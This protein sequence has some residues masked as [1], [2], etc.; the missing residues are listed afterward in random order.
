MSFCKSCNPPSRT[1]DAE[2]RR[3]LPEGFAESVAERLKEPVVLPE[4][5]RLADGIRL[6]HSSLLRLPVG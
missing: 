5:N 3:V 1:S 2:T 6:P 4:G